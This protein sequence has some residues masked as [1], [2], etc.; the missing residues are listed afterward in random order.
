MEIRFFHDDVEKF[1]RGLEKPTIAK[2]LRTIDLLETFGHKL[3]MP[4]SKAIG[5]ELFELRVRGR[6]EVRLIYTFHRSTVVILHGF[7]K[8]SDKIPQNVLAVAITRK[9][10]LDRT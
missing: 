6:Q 4:H 8:K 3:G 5:G 10:T 1:I 7:L 2:V 9:T